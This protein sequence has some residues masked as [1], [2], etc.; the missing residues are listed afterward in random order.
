LKRSYSIIE[1]LGYV[2]KEE[3]EEE[4]E[5]EEGGYSIYI[6]ESERRNP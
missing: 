4:E 5:E 3:E 1:A 2:A 6:A